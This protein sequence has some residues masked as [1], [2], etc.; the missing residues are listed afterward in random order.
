MKKPIKHIRNF[1][2]DNLYL[3]FILSSITICTAQPNKI[4]PKYILR[5]YAENISPDCNIYK[6][7]YFRIYDNVTEGYED[8]WLRCGEKTVED[9]SSSQNHTY[10]GAYKVN[11]EIKDKLYKFSDNESVA[12]IIISPRIKALLDSKTNRQSG[13]SVT[14]KRTGTETLSY[15]MALPYPTTVPGA[16]RDTIDANKVYDSRTNGFKIQ[17]K[18]LLTLLKNKSNLKI[19]I[20]G[21]ASES[22]NGEGSA[23]EFNNKLAK[24]RTVAGVDFVLAKYKE[25]NGESLDFDF[26]R[27][28]LTFTG[29]DANRI[30]CKSNGITNN[31]IIDNDDDFVIDQAVTFRVK[32]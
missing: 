20:V 18:N 13:E 32:K 5:P 12:G 16:G 1:T 9:F 24:D 27:E 21:S 23:T 15:R 3:F 11:P 17:F 30:T 25:I 6:I 7:A 28:S 14:I 8:Y 31:D 22:Y 19:E 10:W 2:R 29:P 26:D 4:T